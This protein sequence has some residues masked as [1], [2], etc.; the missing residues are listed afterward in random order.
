MA[1][2]APHQ[3]FLRWLKRFP[4]RT[5]RT[6]SHLNYHLEKMSPSQQEPLQPNRHCKY[7]LLEGAK[8]VHEPARCFLAFNCVF[9]CRGHLVYLSPFF[10]GTRFTDLILGLKM[11]MMSPGFKK[12]IILCFLVAH[13]GSDIIQSIL[14]P[15][16]LFYPKTINCILNI[17]SI[18]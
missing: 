18:L 9:P 2:Q 5:G 16:V 4:P 8:C 11:K 17:L 10:T 7:P 1:Q 15:I 14:L 13:S 6:R 3:I 12:I